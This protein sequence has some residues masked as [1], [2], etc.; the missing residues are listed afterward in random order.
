MTIDDG[1]HKGVIIAIEERHEPHDYVDII[2]EFEEG[3]RIKSNYPAFISSESQLGKLLNR[4]GADVTKVGEKL[5][6]ATNLLNRTCE[7]MTLKEGK[8]SNVI[9]DSLK[10][11]E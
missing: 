10:P 8:Y 11:R 6:P 1:L 9:R 7:F 5:D 3:K 4:F 2:I